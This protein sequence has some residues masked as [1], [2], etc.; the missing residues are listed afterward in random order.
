MTLSPEML[1]ILE[2]LGS[3]L[4]ALGLAYLAFAVLVAV[5]LWWVAH[6]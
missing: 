4:V 1:Y 5:L 3:V 2:G 6:W